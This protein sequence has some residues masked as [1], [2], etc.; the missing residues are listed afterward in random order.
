[1]QKS[2]IIPTI[3]SAYFFSLLGDSLFKIA[4][5]LFIYTLTQNAR[6]TSLAY[7]TQFLPY[8]LIMP[9][10]GG[11]V[12]RLS[13]K[14]LLL[15]TD[16]L[17][18]VGMALLA[19]YG[20]LVIQL[21]ITLWPLFL[22]LFLVVTLDT[23]NHP[24]FHAFVPR[25]V[26]AATLPKINSGMGIMSNILSVLGAL[27]G[28][29]LVAQIGVIPVFWANALSF[30]IS[31]VLILQLPKD[32]KDNKNNKDSRDK[33]NEADIQ[34][35]NSH[36]TPHKLVVDFQVHVRYTFRNPIAR[37][38]TIFHFFLQCRTLVNTR[39]HDILSCG[40]I[41][42]FGHKSWRRYGHRRAGFRVR[43]FYRALFDEADQK[44]LA[45]YCKWIFYFI[46]NTLFYM[47]I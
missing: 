32:S 24:A 3:F 30:V 27:L 31:F 33:K 29:A 35:N 13:K 23:V 22:F 34:T 11:F 26:P 4:F 16:A 18:T 28:G 39:W 20:F 38:L 2:K 21:H 42:S 47:G 44:W 14:R 6:Y 7:A 25:L 37:F 46:G 12:D 10:M 36:K 15:G 5:P 45:V 19:L 40:C 1:M 17:S 8:V 41:G 9:F 43:F